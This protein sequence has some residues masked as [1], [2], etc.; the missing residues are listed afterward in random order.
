MAASSVTAGAGI[1]ARFCWLWWG[2]W[3]PGMCVALSGCDMSTNYC[4]HLRVD[5]SRIWPWPSPVT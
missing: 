4:N 5:N 1:D 2:W 3:P